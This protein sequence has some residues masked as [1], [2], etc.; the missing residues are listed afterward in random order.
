VALF[1]AR[2]IKEHI[3]QTALRGTADARRWLGFSSSVPFA[4]RD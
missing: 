4:A 1:Y 2:E 3:D